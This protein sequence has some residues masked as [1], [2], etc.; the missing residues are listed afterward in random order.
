MEER[1]PCPSVYMFMSRWGWLIFNF[2]HLL[3]PTVFFYDGLDLSYIC[4]AIQ[5]LKAVKQL[6]SIILTP[7]VGDLECMLKCICLDRAL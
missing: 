1:Q 3:P 7:E 2:C 6:E 5:V 4:T